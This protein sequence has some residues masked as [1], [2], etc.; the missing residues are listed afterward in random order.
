MRIVIVGAGVA[1]CI[2]ARTLAQLP[3]AEVICLERVA[4]D[5]H[6]ESGTGLNIGP[7]AVQALRAASG[8]SLKVPPR[9]LSGSI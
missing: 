3:G 7:N 2:M 5:D 4:R 6:S 8:S 9:K 1:G